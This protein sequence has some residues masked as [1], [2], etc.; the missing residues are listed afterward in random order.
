ARGTG[1]M[2][3]GAITEKY[4]REGKSALGMFFSYQVQL[5]FLTA[6]PIIFG[7]ILLAEDIIPVLYGPDYI[8]VVS[9]VIALFLV[10]FFTGFGGTYSA[11]LVA[12]EKPQYFLWTKIISMINIPLNI[13][14]IPRIGVIG[15]V[16]ATAIAHLLTMSAQIF[17]TYRIASLKF[18]FTNV[19]KMLLCGGIMLVGVFLF[20]ELVNID[21]MELKLFLEIL[22]G[23]CIYVFAVLNLNA[24]DEEIWKFM[25]TKIV[26]MRNR[27]KIN[28]VL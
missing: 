1:S 5:V 11:V 21:I 25:P 12:L 10:R 15:A 2:L 18:P 27:I 22:L 9:L 19:F 28:R 24:L 4:K 17:L 3:L 14:L 6:V 7:G 20:K 16:I 13:L 8:S 26:R 23:A